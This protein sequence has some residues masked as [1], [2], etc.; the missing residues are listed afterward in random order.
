M[1]I[2]S[3]YSRVRNTSATL[4]RNRIGNHRS[5]R[6]AHMDRVTQLVRDFRRFFASKWRHVGGRS[7]D[8]QRSATD[9]RVNEL[10]T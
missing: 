2:F 8:P 6:T 7:E 4:R 1:K 3:V 10:F 5:R 9:R